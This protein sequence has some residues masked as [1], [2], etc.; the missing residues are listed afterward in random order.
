MNIFFL[1]FYGP[2]AEEGW[3]ATVELEYRFFET[4]IRIIVLDGEWVR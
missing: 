2:D 4:V 3:Y 1:N